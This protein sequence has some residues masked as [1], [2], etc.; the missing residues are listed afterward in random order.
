MSLCSV[1]LGV[2]E[3]VEF[4]LPHSSV[5]GEE[6]QVAGT[7]STSCEQGESLQC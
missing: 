1:Y 2:G 4:L 3:R 6:A 7:G 5:Q